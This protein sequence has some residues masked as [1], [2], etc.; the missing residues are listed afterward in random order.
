MIDASTS[1]AVAS[2]DSAAFSA[3]T[4]APD[5]DDTRRTPRAAL[6]A[7]SSDSGK[8]T[9]S[10][11]AK[12]NRRST[13]PERNSNSISQM[14]ARCADLTSQIARIEIRRYESTPSRTTILQ[15][16]DRGMMDQIGHRLARQAQLYFELGR[17][18]V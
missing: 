18:A 10:S 15:L 8:S 11:R 17:A 4:G 14:S 12:S 5:A 3:R 16:R 9:A 1:P 7:G 13:R 6:L 2:R